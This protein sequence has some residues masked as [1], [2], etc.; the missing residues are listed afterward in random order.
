[1]LKNLPKK[2]QSEEMATPTFYA[3]LVQRPL[4]LGLW[5]PHWPV[6]S[7]MYYSPR[8]TLPTFLGTRELSVQSAGSSLGFQIFAFFKEKWGLLAI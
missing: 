5:L 6:H 2:W 7:K 1:M 3:I 8:W 4:T